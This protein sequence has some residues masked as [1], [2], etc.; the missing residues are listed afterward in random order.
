MAS[1][2]AGSG[3]RPCQAE[4]G[5]C[6]AIL[7]LYTKAF[8]GKIT[9]IQKYGDM[10]PDP[11]FP[12]TDSVKNLVLHSR[13]KIDGMEFMCSDASPAKTHAVVEQNYLQGQRIS[14][15]FP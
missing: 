9:E 1:A 15:T 4:H 7:E 6:P 13:L 5:S 14:S 8:D 12:I 11:N 3:K 10:P 2:K